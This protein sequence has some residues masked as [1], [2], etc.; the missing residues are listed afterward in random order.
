MREVSKLG[1]QHIGR[2][3]GV[4]E[5]RSRGPAEPLGQERGIDRAE[6][7]LE[8]Q[9]PIGQIVQTRMFADQAGLNAAADEKNRR[10]RA[11]VGSAAGV[12]LDAAAE[13][14]ED[15]RHHAIE[16]TMGL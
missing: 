9:V 13:L 11:V 10:R 7:K 8:F 1:L 14:T 6:V 16:L 2:R 5:D 12:F 4:A 3:E 15:E